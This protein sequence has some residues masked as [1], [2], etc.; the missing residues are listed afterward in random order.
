M[1]RRIAIVSI[2]ALLSVAC[3]SDPEPEP[4]S[5][6]GQVLLVREGIEPE[7]V[8]I[9]DTGGNAGGEGAFI[10]RPREG[11]DAIDCRADAGA[12]LVYYNEGTEFVPAS[13]TK[14]QSFP[15]NLQ[16]Q[17]VG[18]EGVFYKDGPDCTFIAQRAGTPEVIEEEAEDGGAD[19]TATPRATAKATPKRS[20][21]D[22]AEVD[23]DADPATSTATD[24]RRND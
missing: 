4:F 17:L 24:T 23:K 12:Y 10:I 6:V 11:E 1:T 15:Q 7:G 21:K 8:T 9:E 2:V 16:G 13:I 3:G 18:V 14:P 19:A 20:P 5:F 22:G